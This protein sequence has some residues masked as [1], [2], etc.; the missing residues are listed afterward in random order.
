MEINEKSFENAVCSRCGEP[1][2]L[3]EFEYF[4]GEI[5]AEAHFKCEKCELEEHFYECDEDSKEDYDYWSDTDSVGGG[6]HG[7][8]AVCP[9]CGSNGVWQCDFMLSDY[10]GEEEIPEDKD[11]IVAEIL[12]PHCGSNYSLIGV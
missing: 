5:G 4:D 3:E 2:K 8:D 9:L 11:K 6:Y 7:Y 1:L 10:Y 12:C